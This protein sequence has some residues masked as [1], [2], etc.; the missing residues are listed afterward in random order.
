TSSHGSGIS[1]ETTGPPF[2]LQA[3]TLPAFS[4]ETQPALLL[5]FD[6]AS[7]LQRQRIMLTLTAPLRAIAAGMRRLTIGYRPL[8]ESA[9]PEH[10]GMLS[11]DSIMTGSAVREIHEQAFARAAALA[12]NPAVPELHPW[13]FGET[14]RTLFA[15]EL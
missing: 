14:Q 5:L 9:I 3:V 15:A 6:S 12:A 1:G 11:P 10:A 8:I 2:C 7:T 13:R 4:P